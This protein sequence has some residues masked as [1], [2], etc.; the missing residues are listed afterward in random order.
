MQ[1][2][3]LTMKRNKL[4]ETKRRGWGS[5]INHNLKQVNLKTHMN[6]SKAYRK[7]DWY[8]QI[9]NQT[10]CR[11]SVDIGKYQVVTN[12]YFP[13][14]RLEHTDLTCTVLELPP[15]PPPSGMEA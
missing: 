8:I 5:K 7:Y 6:G 9:H 14:F 12:Q 1:T 15:P 4:C 10:T 2:G 13:F 3:S 11:R